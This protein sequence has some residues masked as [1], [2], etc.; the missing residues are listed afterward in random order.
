MEPDRE[1][2]VL[3]GSPERLV[4]RVVDRLVAVVR[5]RPDEGG[6]EAELFAHEAHLGDREIDILHRQHRH[7][8]Q[9]VR[10]GLAV[11]GEPAV[12]GTAHRGGELRIVDRAGEQPDA[13]VK[14]GGIDT[15]GIHVRDARVRVEAAGLAV[16]VGHRVGLDDALARADRADTADAEPRVDSYAPR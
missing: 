9:P 12:I 14:E 8:E 2:E 4:H 10:I 16:L 11:I 6:L 15:V 1:I 13:R 5:V 7:A 3:G